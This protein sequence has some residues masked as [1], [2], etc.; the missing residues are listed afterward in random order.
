MK[1]ILKYYIHL[2]LLCSVAGIMILQ[3]CKK[4][5]AGAPI[6][7][8]VRNYVATPGDSIVQSIIPGQWVVIE[9]QNLKDAILILFDGIPA[10]INSAMYTDSYAVVQVPSVIPF[11]SVPAELLNTIQYSTTEGSTTFTF[12]V[13][14][15]PPTITSIS[16]EN[17]K[18]GDPVIV[19]GT[20]LF[21]IKTITWAGT[22][23]T[24]YT[25]SNDGLML[26]F[27][28]PELTQSGP[29]QIVTASGSRT[30]PYNVNDVKS[31]GIC[32]FDDIS[33]LSW[34]PSAVINSATLFPGGRGYY[35][36]LN[37][38]GIGA[39]DFSWW[40]GGR[41][42]NTNAVQWVPTT[43]MND[44][45]AN[46]ALKFE[47]SVPV[48]WSAG[49]LFVAANYSWTYI[50]RCAPWLNADGSTSAFSTG[51]SWR[52]VTIPF[53]V[54]K[55]KSDAGVN[56]QGTPLTKFSDLLGSSGNT[57]MNIWFIND[58]KTPVASYNMAIDNIRVVKI[59]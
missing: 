29:L 41:G 39:G 50:A 10:T 59:K 30:T 11:P 45:V 53:S 6:I 20:N 13:V 4:E 35:A 54:F 49:T 52:T 5:K 17:A 14:A 37:A 55:T 26:S 33:T 40:N 23:I 18:V 21:L 8:S 34:G 24:N 19:H 47:I 9:G 51:S 7:T 44:T 43:A 1:K 56:G 36:Q 38:T 25:S 31:G 12:N 27:V 48:P 58:G 32:N 42:I 16:N 28:L 46:Y 22:P 57:G 2:L 3:S 15:P